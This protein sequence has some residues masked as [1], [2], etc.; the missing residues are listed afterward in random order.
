MATSGENYWPPTGRTSWPLTLPRRN[1]PVHLSTDP[2]KRCFQLEFEIPSLNQ[3]TFGRFL[4]PGCSP[5]IREPAQFAAG[6]VYRL[7]EAS[8]ASY[9]L[10]GTEVVC[11]ERG[12]LRR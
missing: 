4:P 7:Y 10:F 2:Q 11:D 6:F 5:T 3:M 8:A 9:S 1:R 12:N